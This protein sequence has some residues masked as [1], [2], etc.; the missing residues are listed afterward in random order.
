MPQSLMYSI[1]AIG[2][3]GKSERDS[4]VGVCLCTLCEI[5]EQNHNN[6]AALD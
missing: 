4:F 1:I 3:D 2:N 5:G 6:A